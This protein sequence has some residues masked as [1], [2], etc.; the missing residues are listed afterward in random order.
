VIFCTLWY[1]KKRILVEALIETEEAM[2][3]IENLSKTYDDGTKALA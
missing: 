3:K 1:Y 2:I